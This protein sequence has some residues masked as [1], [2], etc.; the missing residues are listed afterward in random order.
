MVAATRIVGF[1][2]HHFRKRISSTAVYDEGIRTSIHDVAGELCGMRVFHRQGA[3]SMREILFR[4][5]QNTTSLSIRLKNNE[6]D[7][8]FAAGELIRSQS[9]KEGVIFGI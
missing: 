8:A 7:R 5:P 2:L 3:T 4:D 1:G 6:P 9:A